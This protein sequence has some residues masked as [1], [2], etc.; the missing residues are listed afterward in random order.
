MT[1]RETYMR[2]MEEAFEGKRL[3]IP[4]IEND[5]ES[6]S[7]LDYGCGTGKL[8]YE[9]AITYKNVTVVG[10]DPAADMI[11]EANRLHSHERVTFV[12]TLDKTKYDYI[13]FNSVLHEV[14]SDFARKVV[15]DKRFTRQYLGNFIAGVS[16]NNLKNK[17]TMIV[18]DGFSTGGGWAKCKIRDMEDAASFVSELLDL[19]PF[20][21]NL[22]F[23]E[24]YLKGDV[25]SIKEFLNKYTWGR[26]SLLRESQ[27]IIHFWSE[28]DWGI[29]SPMFE[30]SFMYTRAADYFNYLDR[31]IV[32]ND[33]VDYEGI[34]IE[35][36]PWHPI[37]QWNTHIWVTLKRRY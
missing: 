34:D 7:V 11:A 26:E 25:D 17:G 2:R 29:M 21:Y 13:L 20:G 12:E 15:S 1:N 36:S 5:K 4:L 31:L 19:S 9:I 14:W 6:F 30:I 24:G 22:T 16:T 37:S 8:A 10:Y 28:D 3:F 18:R 32:V 23:H 35:N 27:E 33:E